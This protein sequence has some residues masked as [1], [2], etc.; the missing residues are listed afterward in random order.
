M[1]R[2]ILQLYDA[3]LAWR[4]LFYYLYAGHLQLRTWNVS[5]VYDVAAIYGTCSAISHDKGFVLHGSAF[6]SM[7]TVPSMAVFCI[8]LYRAFQLALIFTG[9]TFVFMFHMLCISVVRTYSLKS[10]LLLS[11]SHFCLL[12]LQCVTYMFHLH[13]HELWCTIYCYGWLSV[14][15]YWF[16]SMVILLRELFLVILIV[17]LIHADANVACL[18]FTHIS[19]HMVECG[20]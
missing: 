4:L 3:T 14:F 11:W 20:W 19:L 8:T 17:I 1:Q 12:Q 16:N 2:P 15:T 13:C 10:F 18:I 9:V 6:R 5:R 7:C